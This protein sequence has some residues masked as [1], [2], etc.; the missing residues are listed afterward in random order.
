MLALAGR[1][2][3]G[4]RVTQVMAKRRPTYAHIVCGRSGAPR[5][6]RCSL[7]FFCIGAAPA[8]R[9]DLLAAENGAR[10]HRGIG[11]ALVELAIRT[12]LARLKFREL[13]TVDPARARL[14]AERLRVCIGF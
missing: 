1:G 6:P 13:L 7:R 2:R 3:S 5:G 14:V 12:G 8:F 10:R 11:L 4:P 9:I